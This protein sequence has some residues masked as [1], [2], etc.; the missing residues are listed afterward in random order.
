[1]GNENSNAYSPY[2]AKGGYLPQL[3][4]ELNHMVSNYLDVDSHRRAAATSS[5]GR[6][7]AQTVQHVLNGRVDDYIDYLIGH[8]P[9]DAGF[10]A[11]LDALYQKRESFVQRIPNLGEWT[12]GRIFEVIT[13][14]SSNDNLPTTGQKLYFYL[15]GDSDVA[16]RMFNDYLYDAMT[17]A[18]HN[19]SKEDLLRRRWI[20]FDTVVDGMEILYERFGDDEGERIVDWQV[21]GEEGNPN[22]DDDDF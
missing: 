22:D 4:N 13:K 11:V 10:Q 6:G 18:L 16:G 21:Y 15:R 7:Y 14:M 3:P 19:W 20:D 5:R 12:I 17:R 2:S 9:Q 1:M 8:D